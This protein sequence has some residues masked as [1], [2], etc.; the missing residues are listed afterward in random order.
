MSL[1]IAANVMS[2]RMGTQEEQVERNPSRST[3][4]QTV[5]GCHDQVVVVFESFRFAGCAAPLL[6]IHMIKLVSDG[7]DRYLDSCGYHENGNRDEQ[8]HIL[9]SVLGRNG[10][11]DAAAEDDCRKRSGKSGFCGHDERT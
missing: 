7:I 6:A 3:I 8:Y 11:S 4:G 5:G 2:N 9:E 10:G 1:N